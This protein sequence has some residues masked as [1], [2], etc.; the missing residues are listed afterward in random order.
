MLHRDLESC[1]TLLNAPLNKLR[2]GIVEE[3]NGLRSGTPAITG[4]E[5]G[6]SVWV[7]PPWYW[8]M[9]S[10]QHNNLERFTDFT[11][12][13]RWIGWPRLKRAGEVRLPGMP[14]SHVQWTAK[15]GLLGLAIHDRS[16]GVKILVH[17]TQWKC[18]SPTGPTRREFER[19]H[20][21]S[22][23]GH[24]RGEIRRL[25]AR[26]GTAVGCELRREED[27]VAFG[28]LTAHTQREL[29]L[30]EEE[31]NAVGARLVGAAPGVAKVIIGTVNL[32]L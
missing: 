24:T 28:C 32:S 9:L 1:T 15:K 26:H 16:P 17:S 21:D 31:C 4:N 6:V 19:M 5:V 23:L 18:A 2:D 22:T 7:L 20:P 25:Q 27:E 12:S 10:E 29:V 3:I 30:V 11:T 14:S 13:L 8:R